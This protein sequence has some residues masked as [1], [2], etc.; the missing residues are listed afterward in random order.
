[1]E[2]L[3]KRGQGEAGGM[4]SKEKVFTLYVKAQLTEE[5]S[6]HVG[7][8]D[9]GLTTLYNDGK[10]GQVSV[11]ERKYP[12]INVNA[13]VEGV[14]VHCKDIV[15]M[16]EVEGQILSATDFFKKMLDTAATFGGEEVY[17]F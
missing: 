11:V 9:M 14:N 16:M 10:D 2:L 5:E 17:Q 8:Y 13:L 12:I 3:V 15:T 7:R 4:F 1:M 6:D